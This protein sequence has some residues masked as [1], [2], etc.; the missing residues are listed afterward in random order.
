M[1]P[2]EIHHS[3]RWA[4]RNRAALYLRTAR[5]QYAGPANARARAHLRAEAR[6]C[7]ALA[8]ALDR[9]STADF[10]MYPLPVIARGL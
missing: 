5:S 7:E 4:L 9:V 10:V 2:D 3:I 8:D 1:T 6:R